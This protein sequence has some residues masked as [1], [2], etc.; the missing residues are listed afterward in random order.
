MIGI[1]IK[2]IGP[3]VDIEFENH[4]PNEQEFLHVLDENAN[5]LNIVVEVITY[6]GNNQYRGVVINYKEDLS[7]LNKTC[8]GSNNNKDINIDLNSINELK[9]IDDYENN[10]IP[11]VTEDC[12]FHDNL[13]VLDIS[14]LIERVSEVFEI[15]IK[16]IEVESAQWLVEEFNLRK[17]KQV[18]NLLKNKNVN[19]LKNKNDD[20]YRKFEKNNKYRK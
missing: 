15:K 10:Y 7:L 14:Q 20:W 1:I 13:S 2:Q 12:A 6:I 8:I 9:N 17:E 18:V 4:E 5:S 3:V 19:L 16:P 11:Y